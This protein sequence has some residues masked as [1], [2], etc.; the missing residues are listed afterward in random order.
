[1]AVSAALVL[2]RAAEREESV[3]M[4][5]SAAEIKSFL[6]GRW[7]QPLRAAS[8]HLSEQVRQTIRREAP[9]PVPKWVKHQ[10]F[11]RWL[12]EAFAARAAWQASQP[13]EARYRF[14]QRSEPC[15]SQSVTLAYDPRPW[16]VLPEED[17]LWYMGM[18]IERLYRI[19]QTPAWKIGED[20][21]TQTLLGVC[22]HLAQLYAE[23]AR[24]CK[25]ERARKVAR[26]A[27]HLFLFWDAGERHQGMDQ[28]GWDDDS[29]AWPQN[30]AAGLAGD[31]RFD[32]GAALAALPAGAAAGCGGVLDGAACR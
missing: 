18:E 15:W 21:W 23:L 10:Y 30:V 9:P 16:R 11:Q 31:A 19:T 29:L 22:R 17:I 27:L 2:L 7:S 14:G 20:L 3:V 8:P 25:A 32:G 5:F 4:C 1:M 12:G 24:R 28:K 6:V 26:L 13:G